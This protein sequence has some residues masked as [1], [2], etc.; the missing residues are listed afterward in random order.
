MAHATGIAVPPAY[1]GWG[2]AHILS[3]L[4]YHLLQRPDLS[5]L[6]AAT[7]WHCASDV[8]RLVAVG[9]P[10]GSIVDTTVMRVG[11]KGP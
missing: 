7:I 8:L 1:V 9:W 4:N 5:P 10:H 2:G 6:Q 11:Q 3:R